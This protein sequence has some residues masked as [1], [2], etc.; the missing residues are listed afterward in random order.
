MLM[1]MVTVMSELQ[2]VGMMPTM[3]ADLDVGTGSIGLLVSIYAVG[4]TL[5]GPTFA[6]LLGRRP[7]KGALF[8]VIT[9]YAIAQVLV[10]LVDSLR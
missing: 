8:A 6:F 9:C 3:A 7:S 5:G 4:M 2:G 1:I 10:P